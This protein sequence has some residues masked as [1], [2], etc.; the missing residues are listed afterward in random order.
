CWRISSKICS[1]NSSTKW[2]CQKTK[3][4]TC[5]SSTY[6]DDILKSTD[7]SM[8]RSCSYCLLHPEPIPNSY[9]YDKKPNLIFLRVFGALCYPINDSED[10]GKFQAKADIGIFVGYAPSRKG[11]RIY[12][13]RTRRLMETIHVTFDE[14]H[15]T[16]APVR[17]SSGPEPIISEDGPKIILWI[18]SL[19]IPLVLYLPEMAVIEDCWFQAM[20]DEIHKF[21]RLEV[22]ELVPRPIYVMVIALK[23][24]YKVKLDE[25]GDVLKNK[26]RLVAKGYRQEEGIDFEESFTPVAR[27]KAIRIVKTPYLRSLL[28]LNL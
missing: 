14:M 26:V 19:A 7:V 10:L 16:M 12:N 8:G 22:W 4:Y 28:N 3:S 6:N 15:Q 13:K 20:Q 2:R 24:I 23:W 18:T 17:M 11:Y 21:N 25:Y 5:R 1:K 9:S 27:I